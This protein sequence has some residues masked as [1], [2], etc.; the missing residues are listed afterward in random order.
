MPTARAVKASHA[1]NAPGDATADEVVGQGVVLASDESGRAPQ[2]DRGHR[3]VESILDAAEQIF[4][5]SGVNAATTNA[6]ADRAGASVGSL[7][8]FFPSKD[9]VL[10]AVAR[11]YAERMREVNARAMPLGAIDL[12]LAELFERIIWGHVRFIDATPAFGVV[13][14][15]TTRKYGTC[16]IA[17]ELDEAIRSQVQ[18]F[19]QARLPRMSAERRIASTRLSVL[20]VGEAVESTVLMSSAEREAVLHE[21]R[22]MLVRYFE[23]L[24][25]EFGRG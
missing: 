7:Y 14:D 16:A 23:P 19:L 24:D 5:E 2:Q 18:T 8:H 1:N 20:T 3:R 6:I 15:A 4:A 12:P 10:L 9:A 11:R 22:D 25:R 21:L 13:Q 17:D